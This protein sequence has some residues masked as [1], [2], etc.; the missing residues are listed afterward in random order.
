M[1]AE[2]SNEK[3]VGKGQSFDFGPA[4][5][6]A[7]LG[8]IRT[9]LGKD[10]APSDV[11]NDIARKLQDFGKPGLIAVIKHLLANEEA[12]GAVAKQSY[13][14]GNGFYKLVLVSEEDFVIRTNI[15]MPGMVAEENLHDHRWHMASAVITGSLESEI[16]EDAASLS[17]PEYSEYIY[18]GKT[19]E[20]DAYLMPIGKTR[21]TLK[22]KVIHKAG[23]SY[24]LP[25][26]VMHRI[27]SCGTGLTSTL[28]CHPEAAKRWGRVI[29]FENIQPELERS[30]L[31]NDQLR[32]LF[33]EYLSLADA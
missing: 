8:N 22:E 10:T 18:V 20:K 24:S 21:I 23:E 32:A 9:C 26:H 28:M 15:W 3:A 29:T 19:A 11:L 17:A 33:T 31:S 25:S 27:V 16:W 14:H 5:F 12:L 2:F 1:Y 6:N 13:L 4:E 30:Y 7:L